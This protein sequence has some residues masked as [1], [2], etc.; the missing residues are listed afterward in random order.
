MAV[1]ADTRRHG[2]GWPR[3]AMEATGDTEAE[4]VARLAAL[5][6]GRDLW[7]PGDGRAEEHVAVVG[8]GVG[9]RRGGGACRPGR[10]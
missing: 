2:R 5:A 4:A 1:V 3:E 6:E 10:A 7:A 8:A 9:Q